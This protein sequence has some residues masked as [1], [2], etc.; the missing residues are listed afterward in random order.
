MKELYAVL[1]RLWGLD[2][3]GQTSRDGSKGGGTGVRTGEDEGV[4]TQRRRER[5]YALA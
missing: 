1:T 2:G 5:E 4:H 3:S